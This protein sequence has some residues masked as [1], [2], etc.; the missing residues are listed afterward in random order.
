MSRESMT[1]VLNRFAES[2][3]VRD[4]LYGFEADLLAIL[5]EEIESRVAEWLGDEWSVVPGDD[6]S[7]ECEIYVAPKRW[8]IDND[9][10]ED[11]PIGLASCAIWLDGD[12]PAW[13]MLGEPVKSSD[14]AI[15][16]IELKALEEHATTGAAKQAFTSVKDELKAAL[17]AKN[18]VERKRKKDGR[19]FERSLAL[20]PEALADALRTEEWDDALEEIRV[21]WQQC[22]EIGGPFIDR[23][24][25]AIRK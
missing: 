8:L 10:D 5:H 2:V 25:S 14:S 16:G 7:E 19:W 22:A 9:E 13:A 1:F 11:D 18:F 24:V 17:A 3:Q 12:E 6:F 4:A 20:R 15:I 21:A 23:V